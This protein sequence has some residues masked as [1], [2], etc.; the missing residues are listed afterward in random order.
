VIASAAWALPGI[1]ELVYPLS[2]ITSISMS[3]ILL[4]YLTIL[5]FKVNKK[6]IISILGLTTVAALPPMWLHTT[7]GLESMVF[8]LSIAIVVYLVLHSKAVE[9]NPVIILLITLLAGLLR[10]D[11]FIFLSIILIA[12]LVA[13]SPAWKY[14]LIGIMI[15]TLLLFSWRFAT[16]GTW[17]PNTAL[18]KV[19]FSLFERITGGLDFFIFALFNSGLLIVLI[20]GIGGLKLEKRRIALAGIFI[21]IS[22]LA[23]YIYIGSD[24]GFERH[25][26]GVYFLSAAFS[27]SLWVV[28]KQ[29]TRIL[30]M[31]VF[32]TIAL[33]AI[34]RFEN[35]FDYLNNKGSDP[36]VMLGQ[37]VEENREYYGVL[38]TR[39][40]GKIPFYA[41][42]ECIDALGLN[43]PFLST[44]QRDIFA[45][46]HSAGNDQVAIELAQNHPS[47]KYS[48]F[49]YLNL[50]F[51]RGPEDISL[52]V[53]NRLPKSKVNHGATQKQWENAIAAN[54]F[55]VWSI[56]TNPK[57]AAL[58][59]P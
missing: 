48:I 40:A 11:G 8:G 33:L 26:V 54:D 45:P 21:I 31:I 34:F 39:A 36:W 7:S 59:L 17:L 13:K 19:N 55:L 46:G 27:S 37:S 12:S 15:S 42:G 2:V 43:D 30:F 18:A 16:Y 58:E 14:L 5:V 3:A 51:I 44:L 56:I 50:Q 32:V 22:W 41:S 53:D 4:S 1:K 47:G 57:S 10:S 29:Y 20:F 35:R 9:S 23:Y 24:W 38:V 25:L 6:S 28:A 52:W 49:T